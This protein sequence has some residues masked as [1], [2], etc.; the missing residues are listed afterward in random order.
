MSGDPPHPGIRW[1][2]RDRYGNE[3]YL[4][5]ERWEHIIEADNHPEM[6]ELE[7]EIRA[8]TVRGRR[9][10][11]PGHPEK[12]IYAMAFNNLP[13]GASHIEVVVLFRSEYDGELQ[14]RVKN[15]FV[16]T[17]YLSIPW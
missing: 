10:R 16:L 12:F 5:H 6:A 14:Q 8:T 2:V 9:Q 13:F 11:A 15:N 4:T 17:A 1:T 3:I 7:A